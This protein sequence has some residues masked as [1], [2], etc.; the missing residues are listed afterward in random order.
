MEQEFIFDTAKTPTL[1]FNEVKYVGGYRVGGTNSGSYSI[2]FNLPK[3]PPY[4][5]RLF[6]KLLLGWKWVDVN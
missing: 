3:K 1:T 4:I 5:H 6:C 2:Q